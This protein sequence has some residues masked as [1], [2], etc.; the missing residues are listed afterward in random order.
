M[1]VL[2]LLINWYIYTCWCWLVNP[3][4]RTF[5]TLGVLYLILQ[6]GVNI[7]ISLYHRTFVISYQDNLDILYHNEN[8][9]DKIKSA[10]FYI[11]IKTFEYIYI[12][13]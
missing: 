11:Y 7:S 12:V 10:F 9:T 3:N 6:P 13:P 4:Y 2:N 8:M 1:L 5:Y